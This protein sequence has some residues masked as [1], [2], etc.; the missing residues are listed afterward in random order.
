MSLG[1]TQDI[2]WTVNE[3]PYILEYE[4]LHSQNTCFEEFELWEYGIRCKLFNQEK[5]LISSAEVNHI[6][7]NLDYVKGLINLL[8]KHKVFPIHLYDVVSDQLSISLSYS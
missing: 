4:L 8:L 7:G 3:Q 5:Q 1:N 2:L 6:S